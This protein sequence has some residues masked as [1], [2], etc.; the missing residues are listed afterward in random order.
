MGLNDNVIIIA[1]NARLGHM[2]QLLLQGI[3]RM[4]MWQASLPVIT[5][6]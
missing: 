3:T 4:V 6:G 1:L 5:P 2:L